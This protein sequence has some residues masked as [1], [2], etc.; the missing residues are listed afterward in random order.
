MKK[1]K[2][3]GINVDKEE[4]EM[5]RFLREEF[6]MNISSF[7]RKCIKNKHNELKRRGNDST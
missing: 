4:R 6:D 5:I 2:M 1:D 7:L 3:I